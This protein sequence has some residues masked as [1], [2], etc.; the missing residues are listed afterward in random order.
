MQI[1]DCD[2]GRLFKLQPQPCSRPAAGPEAA[3]PRA[4]DEEHLDAAH[5]VAAVNGLLG[6]A[7]LT[8]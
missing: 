4:P 6:R 3:R 2:S 5:A 8:R 1:G 7:D